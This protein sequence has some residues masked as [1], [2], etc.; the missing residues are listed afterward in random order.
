MVE[1]LNTNQLNQAVNNAIKGLIDRIIKEEI[2]SAKIRL[3]QRIIAET[4]GLV[5]DV[6]RDSKD[7]KST[8]E[9]NIVINIPES[10]N[11]DN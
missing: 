5:V 2:A 9:V 1:R 8:N 6:I 4:Y 10:K 11:P 7:Y 3:E